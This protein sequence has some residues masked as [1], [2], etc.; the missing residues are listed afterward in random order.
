MKVE[1][2]GGTYVMEPLSDSHD[3]GWQRVAMV[4][5]NLSWTQQAPSDFLQSQVGHICHIGKY[6]ALDAAV[7][8][9]PIA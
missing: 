2:S 6:N 7:N 1:Y 9:R 5:S 4:T 3:F 8:V